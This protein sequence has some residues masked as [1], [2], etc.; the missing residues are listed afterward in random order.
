M[1]VLIGHRKFKVFSDRAL[2]ETEAFEGSLT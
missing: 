2:I 1:L